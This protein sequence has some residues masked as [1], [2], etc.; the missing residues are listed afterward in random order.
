[1][2]AITLKSNSHL[3]F[4]F[5]TW[6]IK[7]INFKNPDFC[8]LPRLCAISALQISKKHNLVTMA[9][10]PMISSLLWPTHNMWN[11]IAKI[12]LA[13]KRTFL[14]INVLQTNSCYC[15]IH[16]QTARFYWLAD[17]FDVT[18]RYGYDFCHAEDYKNTLDKIRKSC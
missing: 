5:F 3:L 12:W 8:K 9:C 4:N 13:K 17:G 15:F 11:L 16:W 10:I 2:Q 1:M 7:I 14:R 6:K 18:T